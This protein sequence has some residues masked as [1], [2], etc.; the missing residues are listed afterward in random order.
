MYGCVDVHSNSQACILVSLFIL[1]VSHINVFLPS[2]SLSS[3]CLCVCVCVYVCLIPFS[4]LQ[5]LTPSAE[6][7]GNVSLSL[8]LSFSLYLFLCLTFIL[9][10]RPGNYTAFL[11]FFFGF[12]SVCLQVPH[13]LLSLCHCFCVK[14]PWT[15]IQIGGLRGPSPLHPSL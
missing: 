4:S 11:S 15:I 13:L 9:N 8:S 2:N 3:P 10:A 12:V 1:C 7:A 14:H 6:A 5:L